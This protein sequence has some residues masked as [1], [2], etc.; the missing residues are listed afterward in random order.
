M[1][2]LISTDVYSEA[3]S[4]CGNVTSTLLLAAGCLLPMQDTQRS[5]AIR[6][7]SLGFS[8]ASRD[9]T[10]ALVEGSRGAM[11]SIS[12]ALLACILH[13]RWAPGRIQDL[14]ALLGS[15]GR[16]PEA[17]AV[18]W[19]ALTLLAPA[20]GEAR[21]R[22]VGGTAAADAVAAQAVA[23]FMALIDASHTTRLLAVF[24]LCR[25]VFMI[26]SAPCPQLCECRHA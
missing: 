13:A 14:V 16:W 12:V 5:V 1:D 10:E 23:S 11:P 3:A 8:S 19:A 24:S 25:N 2:A 20:P 9:P 21:C 22:S 18:F 7:H 6:E 17:A 15:L 4:G 26:R